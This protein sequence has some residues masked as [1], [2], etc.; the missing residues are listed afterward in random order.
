[1]AEKPKNSRKGRGGRAEKA[2]K[3]QGAGAGGGGGMNARVGPFFRTAGRRIRWRVPGPAASADYTLLYSS[4]VLV[5][6][7]RPQL[8]MVCF[9]VDVF[10]HLWTTAG[11]AVS[12]RLEA[13]FSLPNGQ[14]AHVLQR[15]V[16]RFVESFSGRHPAIE[17]C[18]C[19]MSRV[20]KHDRCRGHYWPAQFQD[21][22]QCWGLFRVDRHVMTF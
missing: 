9:V 4:P 11:L 6:L 5:F 15:I 17:H 10:A 7:R 18:S 14:L 22:Q 13:T 1:M 3:I 20:L 16:S 8:F 19:S 12:L 21:R 2:G